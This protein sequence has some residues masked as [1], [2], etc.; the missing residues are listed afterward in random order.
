MKAL[1]EARRDARE[2]SVFLKPEMDGGAAQA[3]FLHAVFQLARRELGYAPR[4][5]EEVVAAQESETRLPPEWVQRLG[6]CMRA[7]ELYV[8]PDL[9]GY[10]QS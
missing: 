4:E 10:G 8:E 5:R 3:V 6:D 2:I 1:F 9:R 7:P